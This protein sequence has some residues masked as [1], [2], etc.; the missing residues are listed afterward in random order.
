MN[1]TK[2]IQ[3]LRKNSHSL[4]LYMPY[5]KLFNRIFYNFDIY[6]PARLHQLTWPKPYK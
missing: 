3:A 2:L 4:T 6:H 5:E 1:E